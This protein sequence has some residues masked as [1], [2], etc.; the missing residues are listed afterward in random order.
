MC[1][2]LTRNL[3][4]MNADYIG[5][6]G[7]DLWV[8]SLRITW[9]L[10]LSSLTK[11][12][13]EEGNLAQVSLL[14]VMCILGWI[15][16]V[17]QKPSLKNKEKTW[18]SFRSILST[19]TCLKEPSIQLAAKTRSWAQSFVQTAWGLTAA[20]LYLNR[21]LEFVLPPFCHAND[22]FHN[23]WQRPLSQACLISTN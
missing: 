12:K 20:T 16:L 4:A 3:P 11:W 1:L 10:F 22:P 6:L 19:H 13:R 21:R 5:I 2:S 23:H 17:Y 8:H 18:S 9:T 7:D 14:Q 15:G